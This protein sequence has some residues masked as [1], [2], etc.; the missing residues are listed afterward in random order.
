[1]WSWVQ[2]VGCSGCTVAERTRHSAR[3]VL[4]A[5]AVA[6]LA[7]AGC[8][9][10]DDGAAPSPAPVPDS[11]L[12]AN[13]RI[14]TLDTAQLKSGSAAAA[15]G[16]AVSR[17]PAAAEVAR[18]TLPPLL[19]AKQQEAAHDSGQPV[20]VGI[21]RAVDAAATPE[22]LAG[23]LR[24]QLLPDGARV[25]VLEFV[26]GGA[27]ALRLGL[28]VQ[29]LPEGAW[30]R[31]RGAG[32]IGMA[33]VSAAELAQQHER[34]LQAGADAD[35]ARLYWSP[36]MDGATARLELELPAGADPAQL[37][38]ALP[39]LSQ[40]NQALAQAAKADDPSVGA[41]G[42]CNEDVM[43]RPDWEV[44]SRAVARVFF[45]RGDGTSFLCSGTLLNDVRGSRTPF[46]LT[47]RHC[48]NNQAEASSLLTYWFFRATSC[49]GGVIDTR[50]TLLDGGA[51][52]L[53]TNS[54]SDSALLRLRRAPPADVA[55]A[56]SYFGQ[57]VGVGAAVAGIHHPVG[58]LQKI[59]VGTVDGHANCANNTCLVAGADDGH[60]LRV[61]WKSGT[62]EGGS[63]G[64][65]LFATLQER[66]YVVGA[67]NGGDAS[68]QNPGGTEYYGRFDR[69]F[70]AGMRDWLAAQ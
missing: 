36:V 41:A 7:L 27:Q 53:L 44:Q 29:Q 62:T 16:R 1:M 11:A 33:G 58:D 32:D 61:H 45:T 67:L 20:R 68:C 4:C 38:L 26:A 2:T 49:N 59:S 57:D 3:H 60:V 30:L 39:R 28:L 63:S 56:G 48:I 42:A 50:E 6:L 64:S 21:A 9:G 52:L 40:F 46:F 13:Q 31:F 10:D 23:L 34:N 47:A 24:W 18:I 55:Y 51:D 5:A 8:G 54:A 12:P 35:A 25:A 43:C 14:E 70:D 19:Q 65:P 17:L 37:R 69:A 66:H 15:A 22:A